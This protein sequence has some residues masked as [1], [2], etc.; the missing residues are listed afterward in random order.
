MNPQQF[1][2]RK[3][4]STSHALNFSINHIEKSIRD[5]NHVL[6]I[7]IDFSKAFDTIDHNILLS[8]LWHYGIRG[9][10]HDLLQDYLSKR[11]QYTSVLNEDSDKA[12]VN[13]GVPQGSVL[14]PLLFLIYINDIINCSN[15]SC[16]VLFADDTNIFVSG[17]TYIE[18]INKANSI[19]DAVF[20]YTVANKLYINMEKS[21]FMHFQ[22]KGIKVDEALEN[23]SL[24]I[25]GTEIE[26]VSETKFLGVTIDNKLSWESHVTALT[27]KLK[28]C[29]GQLNRICN[30]IP[31][32][33]YKSLYHTLYESHLSYG[34]T[35]WGGISLVKLRPLFVAQKHC[36][37]ILFGDKEIYF[38]KF[39][40]SARSRPYPLQ[41]LGQEF[42]EKEHTKPLFNI[43]KL[44]TV[45]NLYIYQMLNCTYK[46][47]KFRTPIALHSCFKT[48]NR[49]EGLLLL[50][51]LVSESFVYNATKLWNTFL[52]CCGGSLAN[53]ISSGPGNLKIKI[54]ELIYQ[55]QRLG[56]YNEWHF[57]INFV[58]QQS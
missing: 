40:T 1:G 39:K 45:H 27:K 32:D 7:F 14:G 18:A 41:K 55:R 15:I 33:L 26:E 28:C 34:I 31:K 16:F 30:L 43:N 17:K 53:D 35:V 48:S 4:H 6:A 19:L 12:L 9:N 8:K 56:D 52:S 23:L 42:Y 20:K 5:K 58:L 24:T 47:L 10:A 57:D 36:I 29:T 46:L 2:F 37:R 22:P 11:T 13:Y 54:R 44:M 38:E 50:P 51:K 49:K 3:A 25:N 21:C